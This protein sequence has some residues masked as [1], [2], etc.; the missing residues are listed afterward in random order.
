M[1]L[2]IVTPAPDG[3]WKGNRVTAERWARLLGDLGHDVAVTGAWSGAPVDVLVAL[4]ARKS[5]ESV[6]RLAAERPGVPIVLAL[7]G[8]DVYR[9]LEGSAE[10]QEAVRRA[11][12]LVVLQ[13]LALERVPEAARGRAR[14]IHQS[15]DPPVERIPPRE[16]VFEVAVLSNL[17]SVKDPFL[18]AEAARR[19]P[20]E[21]RVE[22]VH[23]GGPLDEGTAERA[24]AEAAANPRYRW[25][26]AVPREEALALLARARLLALTSRLEGG[27][28]VVSE[29]IAVGTPV[30]ATDI[31]GSVGLLG[32][33][34]PAYVPVGDADAL[35]ALLRRVETDAAFL[36]DLQ[37]R[38]A[39]LRPLVEP[40]RE[41]QAWADLLADIAAGP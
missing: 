25:L 38:V 7:T 27:A 26:G 4:H 39:A 32:A 21:S 24:E 18:P 16:D 10:A 2:E 19:L 1:K 17:R 15:V 11:A 34:Y 40:A 31:D 8:T 41:R 35:A 20:A 13:E 12:A 29:A 3:G 23:A 33:D 14:V 22:V 9:D 28:N 5:A 37:A 36:A 30:V 6:R